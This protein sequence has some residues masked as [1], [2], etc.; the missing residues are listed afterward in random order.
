MNTAF[1]VTVDNYKNPTS[2]VFSCYSWAKIPVHFIDTNANS[3]VGLGRE[4]KN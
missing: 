2:H 1:L 4:I 3:K